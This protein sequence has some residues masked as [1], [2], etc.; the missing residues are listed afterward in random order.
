MERLVTS[1]HCLLISANRMVS[2][3]PVYPIGIAH[4][5]GALQHHGHR[6]DHFDVLASG[7]YPLLEKR[8]RENRYDVI[9][10]SIRNIDTVDSTSPLEL[11]A[12]ITEV[13]HCLRKLSKAP[14]VLGGPGFS[15]MPE[16]LL[17]YL[18]ADYGIVGEGEAAFPQLVDRIMAGEQPGQK[19]F[20]RSLAKFPDC[21]P[22]YSSEVTTYYV[23]HGGMLNVQ[24]KR[25]CAH[26]CIYC[27][28]PTIEGRKLRYRDPASVVEEIKSLSEQFGARY[29][30]FTDGVFNDP[31]DRYLEIAEELIRAGSSLPWC[32]FFRPQNLSGDT[33]RLL[34]RSGMAAMELGTDASTDTTLAA[35]GKGFTF[36]E[37][38]AV[39][40]ALVAESIPC[41]HFIMFGGPGETEETIEQGLIN[42]EK[43]KRSVVFAYLGIRIMPGTKLHTRALREG[44]IT[45]DTDLVRPIFYYSSLVD[46]DFIDSRLRL[47]FRDK[48]N[49]VFP[50]AEREHFIPLL[51]QLG[52]D[53]PLWD[54]LIDN[55]PSQ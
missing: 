51:H 1:A 25:G 53:G 15:I 7:G 10:V 34:K 22:L 5:M 32:A 55:H 17:E 52:H 27:S 29:I 13:M 4:I 41:A 42:I 43:L 26:G 12:D 11:L 36:A 3:Y 37:V 39:N 30:F 21:R 8:L 2:P 9:G 28:Y 38:L 47:A 6:A 44:S 46:R 31:D 16:R 33:L 23:S 48:G 49:R 19:L 54:L 20:S 45:V 14:V 35:L 50:V 24:T 18:N 40:D